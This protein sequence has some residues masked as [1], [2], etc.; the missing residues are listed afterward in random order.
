MTLRTKTL[1]AITLTLVALMVVLSLVLSRIVINTYAEL[2]QEQTQQHLQRALNAMDREIDALQL[3]IQ[4]WSAWDNSRE[5]VTGTRPAYREENNLNEQI[6]DTLRLNM[7]LFFD[8][9]KRLVDGV[10]ADTHTSQIV[11]VP[12]SLLQYLD[13]NPWLFEHTN[14]KSGHTGVVVFPEGPLLLVAFPI[15][16]SN[17]G[18]VNG[19]LVVGRYLDDRNLE[20][21]RNLTELDISVFRWSDD[22]LP[23]D[24]TVAHQSLEQNNNALFVQPLS[25]GEI[26][27]YGMRHDFEGNPA[28]IVRVTTP[29]PIYTA[30]HSSMVSVLVALLI[31]GGVFGVVNLFVLERLVLAR[32][33]RLSNDVTEISRKENDSLRL[34]VVG[35]D[36]IGNLSSLINRMLDAL[37]LAHTRQR[38]HTE[39]LRL[40]AEE[41]RDAAQ[42]ANEMKS[43]FLA[44]MSHELRTPLNSII[45]FTRIV[46]AGMR[47]AVTEAQIEYLNRVYA[48]GEHLLG[49]IND[50]LDLSKIEAGRMEMYTETVRVHEI[51]R[52]AMSTAVGLTKNKPI[53]L[54]SEVDDD[55]PLIVADKIRIRQVLLNLLS[56]AAKFTDEGTITVRAV[57]DGNT[58]VFS[59]ADT[60]IGI[61]ADKLDTIFEEFRQ[62]DEGSSRSYE[63]T[64]LGLSICKRL[65]EMHGGTIWVESTPGEGSTFF[66]SLP[67]HDVPAQDAEEPANL[68]SQQRDGLPLLVIDDDP[69]VVDI[70]ASYL[71]DDGYT[72]HGISDSRRALDEIRRI[73]PAA[74]VLDVMMPYKDG[75]QVL[76]EIKTDPELHAIPVL[77]YTM[78]D[79]NRL[80]MSLGASAY[81]V[82]PIDEAQLRRTVDQIVLDGSTV[83]TIDDDPNVLDLVE[84]HLSQYG[85]YT[86]VKACGGRA[87]LEHIAQA[88][89]DVIL[90]DLMMPE[91]DGFAVLEYLDRESHTSAIPVVV[92]TAK[93]LTKEER[94]YLNSRVGGLLS[95]GMLLPEH[96]P[97]RV[98]QVLAKSLIA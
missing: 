49:L 86:I 46:A 52:G 32:L 98:R 75:W 77:L 69:S 1:V 31:T 78:L 70:V 44:N 62:A 79:E 41:A 87:G 25:N 48:S 20:H 63:G 38:E 71:K 54:V 51:V 35:R 7:M 66:F 39:Q 90:L 72:V 29:R 89:P 47:G 5:F 83:L 88:R 17:Y 11:Q 55:I 76:T 33:A 30:G 12:Q 24:V 42:Q 58:V 81:L 80:G 95:K 3:T 45:N 19:T 28:I 43:R 53:E 10:V 64:G 40:K 57:R 60:G 6:T 65:V 73:Q 67:L 61:P 8:K 96:L 94:E 16:S 14:P 97:G 2:E 85:K 93:D 74:I 92:L 22:S 15:T 27:G 37:E 56:N 4:S 68:L 82:K 34:N 13:A 84:A 91:V 18:P 23:S 9:K 59:V 26:A 36:E 21:L 50:I